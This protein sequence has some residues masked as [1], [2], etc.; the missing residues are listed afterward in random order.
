MEGQRCRQRTVDGRRHDGSGC[1]A[2]EGWGGWGY[3][4]WSVVCLSF[5]NFLVGLS[6]YL[7]GS[8]CGRVEVTLYS[9]DPFLESGVETSVYVVR[10]RGALREVSY[11]VFL[12]V[13]H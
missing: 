7:R 11:C 5:V 3:G 2:P 4:V 9:L 12:K 8:L 10:C 1:K 13:R 6:E